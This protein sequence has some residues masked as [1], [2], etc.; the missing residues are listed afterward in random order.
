MLVLPS[1]PVACLFNRPGLIKLNTSNH[2]T[3]NRAAGI[4]VPLKADIIRG[5]LAE[6]GANTDYRIDVLP[7]VTSTN[8]YLAKQE[9]IGTD[10]VTICVAEQQTQGKGRFGHQWWSPPGVNLY[11]SMRWSLQQRHRQ[12]ET[13]GLWLLVTIAELLE[14]L[15]VAGVRL[16]WPNDIC[17]GNKKL[18]GILVERKSDRMVIGVGL[19]V[20]MSLSEDFRA[21]AGWADLISVHPGW[22][23]CRN[24]LAAHVIGS[25]T[26][27]LV[28]LDRNRPGDLFSAWGRYD[29]MS[30]QE[31][32]FIYQNQRM[33]GVAQGIDAQGRIVMHVNGEKLHLHSAHIREIRL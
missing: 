32:K 6:Q 23:M 31:V 12:Y 19:N 11:L 13:L 26:G 9:Y 10:E 29:L 22:K 15:G 14:Q 30:N 8:D 3:V 17:A 24:E 16:K 27:T 5:F 21:K 18:G 20:A 25:L 1:N 2:K 28:R 33:T 7:I 4:L